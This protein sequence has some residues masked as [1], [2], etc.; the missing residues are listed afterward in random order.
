METPIQPS[1]A[2]T[3][4]TSESP[5][6]LTTVPEPNFSPA[7]QSVKKGQWIFT[8]VMTF[9]ANFF[10]YVT[11]FFNANKQSIISLAL[12]LAALVSLKIVS[13]V[14]DALNDIPLVAPTFKLIGIVYSVWFVS[15][16]LLK[17]TSRQELSTTVQNVVSETLKSEE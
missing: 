2:K 9:L 7:S 17:T 12:I 5:T 15:R 6:A 1:P 11:S 4:D 10:E 8:Q 14:M 3:S 16:Y 13:A